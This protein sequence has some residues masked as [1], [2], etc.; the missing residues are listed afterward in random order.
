MLLLGAPSIRDIIAFPKT[1]SGDLMMNAP[2]PVSQKKLVDYGLRLVGV[3]N[4]KT[5][6]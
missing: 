1:Q 3:D 6:T 5:S 2:T 4:A